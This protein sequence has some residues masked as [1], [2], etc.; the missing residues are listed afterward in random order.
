MMN[1]H[2]NARLFALSDHHFGHQNIIKYCQRDLSDNE[3]QAIKLPGAVSSSNLLASQ[4][5]MVMILAHNELV[6]D[7]DIMIFGGDVSASS[8][9][10]Q[11]LPKIIPKMRGRKIL[12]RGNHDHQSNQDYLD[13]GF[14]SVHDVLKI[15]KFVFCHYP[16]IPQVLA[17]CR[18]SGSLLCCGHTHKPFPDYGDSIPRINLACDVQGR[19]PLLLGNLNLILKR[20]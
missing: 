17:I 8:Q 9:G 12:I 1:F 10:K 13:M 16:N 18:E 4:D 2:P 5:A 15:G 11:W 14:E 6:K 19:T 3:A 7:E 20:N